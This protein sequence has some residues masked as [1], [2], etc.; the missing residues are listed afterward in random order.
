MPTRRSKLHA[1]QSRLKNTATQAYQLKTFVPRPRAFAVHLALIGGIAVAGWVPEAHA[2]TTGDQVAPQVRSYS[3]PAGPLAATLNRFAEEAET[4]LTAPGQITQSKTSQGLNGRYSVQAGFAALLAGTGLEAFRQGDGSFGLKPVMPVDKRGDA[5]LPTITVTDNADP[6]SYRNLLPVS[7]A[8]R[9]P[10]ALRDLPQTVDVVPQAS[11]RD[12]GAASLKEALI[13]TP[14]VTTSTGEGIREQFLIRGFSAISDTYIDGMR[15][16]GNIFRDTYNLE[17]IEVVK[18][19]AGVLLGRGSAGGLI[20][21]VTKRPSATPRSEASVSVG[22]NDTRRST[23]DLN[24]P[25]SENL[26]FRI[27]AMAENADSFRD[28]VWSKKRGLS[29]AST[30]KISPSTLLDLRFQNATDERVFD[31]GIP[32]INGKPA[33][34]SR[35]TYYGAKNPGQNDRGTSEENSFSADLNMQLTD[36]LQ[37][38]NTLS[39]RELEMERRQ[40]TISRLILNTAQPTLA[41]SRSNF[42]S[43]QNDLANKFE[44]IATG[45]W[46]GIRHEL[47]IG[48]EISSEKRDT[49][50]RGGD[51]STAYNINVYNPVLKNLPWEGASI[52]RDGIYNTTTKSLYLQDLLRFNENWVTLVGLRRDWL[53][54]DFENRVGANYARNDSFLSPRIGVVYQP[55][56]V[57]SYYASATRSYQPGSATGVIDPGNSIQPPE[58]ATN[59]EIGS[60]IAFADGKFQLGTSLFQLVKENVPTRDP[61]DATQNI[62]VGEVTAKG[63]ELSAFGDLGYG[64]SL[65]GGIT[66]TDAVVTKS[67]NTT[68]PAVTPSVAATP[69]EGKRAANSPRF[70]ANL[71]SVK[72]LDAEWRVGLGLRHSAESYAST[73]NAIVLP[74]YLLFDAGAFYDSGRWSVALSLRNLTN[75][76][77]YESSTNDLGILP[78]ASRNFLMTAR[79]AF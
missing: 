6:S 39:Y 1:L 31:A 63:V 28:E 76:L 62:Y 71:W 33:E 34:V 25:V 38:R 65:Q 70:T 9:T 56:K 19:P 72:R 11:L 43:K 68:A 40:T 2:Q 49:L 53:E 8:T 51:L 45:H 29:V 44:L 26:M 66:Y 16:G 64:F 52:R 24:Q 69:L 4:L 12:R 37:L 61:S 13:Y 78:G 27:N 54:R 10:I 7:A 36:S 18:G 79:Y 59:Y 50:S 22:S 73:T 20:N 46:A 74:A 17:Q 77:Y 32:G 55:N 23:V 3:I 14:G 48:T 47:M 67:N 5:T 21:M 75:R 30:L 41:L 35:S 42:S 57:L 60:K 58:I 15:D